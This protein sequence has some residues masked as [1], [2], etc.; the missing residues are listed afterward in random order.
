MCCSVAFKGS[1]VTE[2]PEPQAISK[3]Y[4]YSMCSI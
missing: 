3:A 2:V 1:V 4:L